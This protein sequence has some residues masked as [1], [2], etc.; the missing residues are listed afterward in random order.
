MARHPLVKD[1]AVSTFKALDGSLLLAAYII[2]QSPDDTPDNTALREYM[3][4][5]LPEYMLPNAFIMIDSLPLSANGKLN[6]KALPAPD[7]EGLLD[8]EFI[9]PRNDTE[10]AIAAIWQEVLQQERVGVLDNF[11]EIGGHSLLA[12]QVMSRIKEQL[13]VDLE[14]KLIFEHPTVEGLAMQVLEAELSSL[15]EDDMDNLM[16]YLLEGDDIDLDDIDLDGHDLK[17]IDL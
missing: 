13:E 3:R 8:T 7:L 16:Q 6:R 12:T 4:A 14:L 15:D 9:A 1:V 5:S 2:A 10:I 17:D 11:F